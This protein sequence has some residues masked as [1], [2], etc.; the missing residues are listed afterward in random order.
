MSFDLPVVITKAGLQPLSPAEVQAQLVAAVTV[1][2]PGYTYNL[3]GILIEDVLST[4]VAAILELD[5]ARVDT[6]NSLTPYGANDFLLNQIGQMLG[7]E[8]GTA[9]NTSVFVQFSSNNSPGFVI[10]KGFIVSDGNYQYVIQDGGI[11]RTDGTSP[12][13][14]AVASQTGSWAV[15][16][17]TVTRLVTSV[18][19]TVNLTVINPTSGL[20][21]ESDETSADYRARVLTGNLAA[22]QGM[23]R[24][25]K[26][27][28]EN[29]SGVQSRL[30]SVQMQSPNGWKVI[31]GGGDPYE[32]AYAIY[33]ALFDISTLVGSSML[34]EEIVMAGS[35]CVVTTLLNHGY[36]NGQAIEITQAVPSAYNGSSYGVIAVLD[37][38]NFLLGTFFDANDLAAQSWSGGVVSFTTTTPHGVTPDSTFSI[39]GSSPSGYNG[40]FQAIAG[41]TGT[42]LMAALVSDPGSSVT[43][44]Q[45][46][47][48]IANF[49]SLA[50]PPY[51]GD[52]IITPNFRNITATIIDYP[53]SYPVTF[54]NPPQQ[55]VTV[56]A[57]WNTNS[58][59]FVS[60]AAVAQLA[61]PAIV[62]YINS[63]VVGQPINLL[64]L[65]DAFEDAV[66]AL[67][68]ANFIS[69]LNFAIAINGVPT[70]PD[71]GTPKLIEGDP[72]SYFFS[73]SA[74]VTVIQ[75]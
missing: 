14:F 7:I 28:V 41:T 33:Y 23:A 5:S 4:D 8:S 45:L 13:L 72:E 19:G 61:V 66:A 60:P 9:S 31:V 27:L 42:L 69:K 56:V 18:P 16:P 2:N 11:I 15:P 63:I 36:S 50:L 43:L 22:S 58:P 59:N 52:G 54:V 46:D 47:A 64:Q 6:V 40:T 3:P 25:L 55:T 62:T 35:F 48:G 10:G 17:G 70:S 21:G 29:V 74:D 53:D 20:P 71:S 44:G 57:T 1:T 30:V 49:N 39:S 12:L 24:Y 37:E 73:T 26:T 32:V 65:E 34:I 51:V 38:K 68:P 67:L 75:G